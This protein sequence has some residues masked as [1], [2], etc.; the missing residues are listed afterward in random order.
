MCTQKQP[1]NFTEQIYDRSNEVRSVFA[2]GGFCLMMINTIF[3]QA[4]SSYLQ[5]KVLP[6]LKG[7]S[8][9]TLLRE[10]ISRGDNHNIMVKWYTK[11]FMYVD[12]Y[13]VQYHQV[14]KLAVCGTRNFKKIVFD[15]VKDE[16]TAALLKLIQEEREGQTIEGDLIKKC[17]QIYQQMGMG[18]PDVYEG[19]FEK[20]FLGESRYARCY[21]HLACS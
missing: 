21:S 8:G 5:Y 16:V 17:I 9:E 6:A 13:H 12:R 10:F 18:V 2:T 15:A 11:F 4:M 19:E 7:K 20:S 14:P 3:Q 1:Y